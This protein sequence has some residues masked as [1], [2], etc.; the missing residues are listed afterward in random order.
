MSEVRKA[1]EIC[2][3]PNLLTINDTFLTVLMLNLTKFDLYRED[4]YAG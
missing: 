4:D 2:L 3:E 1:V